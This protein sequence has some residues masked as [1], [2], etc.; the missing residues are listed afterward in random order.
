MRKDREQ[1]TV[2]RKSGMSYSDII[3][4]MAIP[5][6]TLSKWFKD[7]NWSN[8]I[9]IDCAD[10]ARNS[11]AIRFAVLNTVRRG[12]LDSLRKQAR[13]DAL[14]DFDDLKYHPLFLAGV[15]SYWMH[16]DMKSKNRVCFSSSDP[17]KVNLFKS[18][19]D[20]IC[21]I[22]K[23]KVW[24]N[25][26]RGNLT[27]LAESFWAEKCGLGEGDFGKTMISGIFDG[28]Y[29]GNTTISAD[30]KRQKIGK[31]GNNHGVCNMVVNSA[32]LKNKILKWMELL[33]SDLTNE[34]Y[35]NRVSDSM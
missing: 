34:R 29:I 21:G 20:K 27:F 30:S 14:L 32:Y 9:A 35:L 4:R 17:D 3:A 22:Q 5:R 13:Q 1:A 33:K 24:L 19:L 12:R 10:S 15:V 7:Q 8:D 18:F 31:I 6:S 28:L 25:L 16:G 11:G 23:P 2:L 26:K